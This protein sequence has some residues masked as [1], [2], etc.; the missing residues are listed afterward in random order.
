MKLNIILVGSNPLPCYIQ[1]AYV[2]REGRD[3]AEERYLPRPDKILFVATKDTGKY[4]DYIK[5][6]LAL[7]CDVSDMEMRQLTLE[8]GRDMEEVERRLKE[9][10]FAVR[11]ECGKEGMHILLNDTGGTKMMTVYSTVAV[12]QFMNCASIVECYVDAV[13][14]RI[15]CH[16]ANHGE[17]VLLPDT[18]GAD[19]RSSVELSIAQLVYLHFGVTGQGKVFEFKPELKEG[20]IKTAQKILTKE[21]KKTYEKFFNQYVAEYKKN[22]NKAVKA[23]EEFCKLDKAEELFR[24]Y[25]SG[26]PGFTA[27]DF[28]LF[29]TGKWLEQYFC[30][31]LFAAKEALEEEGK[32]LEIAWSYVV[33]PKGTRKNFEVD[34]LALRGYVLTLY[35]ISMVGD[36]KKEEGIAKG[37][38][39]EAVYRTEQMA[40]EHGSVEIVN[41]LKE[42]SLEDFKEDL[43]VFN[44]EVKV[45]NREA[46]CNFNDLVK[47]LICEL[48]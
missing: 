31:A 44:R 24:E 46:I 32:S 1:A 48:A 21:Y 33:Q 35:S 45:K 38:W 14:N 12:R 40:G 19:L 34:V 29:G 10:I 18:A 39:F 8:N 7:T 36:G 43:H 20:F 22:K 17:T 6:V 13:E 3:R 23:I 11:S 16:D 28:E 9:E 37:K 26:L 42:S 4:C 5:K 30:L 25:R 47:G 2:L 15:R 41:F 27:D